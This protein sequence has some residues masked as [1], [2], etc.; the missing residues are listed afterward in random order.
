[1]R[2]GVEV[3]VP[4]TNHR[5]VEYLFQLSKEVQCNKK[6]KG[7]CFTRSN[8]SKSGENSDEKDGKIY[9]VIYCI[10]HD[11]EKSCRGLIVLLIIVL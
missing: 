10:N 4:F 9:I 8:T 11:N 6:H 3:R 7:R 5:P 1:M 2:S